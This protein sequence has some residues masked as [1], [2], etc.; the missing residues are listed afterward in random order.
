MSDVLIAYATHE[1][2]TA[3]IAA[4]LAQLLGER[5]L[6]PARFDLG[7]TAPASECVAAAKALV[8]AGSVHAGEHQDSLTRFCL[9]HHDS[10]NGKPSAFLSVSLSA[11]GKDDRNSQRATEQLEHFLDATDWRPTF[12]RSLPGAVRYSTLS[13]PKRFWMRLLQRTFGRTMAR[14]GFPD[15]TVDEE[16]TGSQDLRECADMIAALAQNASQ[17][18]T[19]LASSSG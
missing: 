1:G 11:A 12:A 8:V 10:L 15:I 6:V 7:V 16:F 19:P 18:A 14:E 5:G 13:A 4:T 2:Q 17:P 3:R 9:A